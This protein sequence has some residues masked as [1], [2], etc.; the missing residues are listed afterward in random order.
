MKMLAR[1]AMIGLVLVPYIA[2]AD[3]DYVIKDRQGKRVG[4]VERRG[5]ADRDEY[6]VR[7]MQGKRQ[8]FITPRFNGD[9][10]ERE[11]QIRDR[12]GKRIGTVEE[13]R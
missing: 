10:G 8:L 12:Q 2:L 7:D 9:D 1:V 11:F 13:D 3:D 4:T 5:D 6:V